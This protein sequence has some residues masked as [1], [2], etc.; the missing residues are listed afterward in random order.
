MSLPTVQYA[1]TTDGVN[2]AYISLGDGSPI[3]FA[4]NIFGD[5]FLYRRAWPHVRGV[6]DRLRGLG[7]RVIRYDVR[8]M[9]SSDRD[10]ADWSLAAQVRDIAAV[11]D[12]LGVQRFAL[13]GVDAGTATAVG[14]AVQNQERVSHLVLLSA[15]ASGSR[16]FS[17]PDHR[18]AARMAPTAG[19]EWHILVNLHN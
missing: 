18:L 10:I 11:V 3:V 15:W 9:G 7:W 17:I 12:R 1:K 2:V 5:A 8:G 16:R 14:Y 13:A 4:S 6:T 19:R